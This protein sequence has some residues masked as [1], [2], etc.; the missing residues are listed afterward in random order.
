MATPD[1]EA[2]ALEKRRLEDT[3]RDQYEK[4]EG[5]DT[6]IGEK[7]SE[8]EQLKA[9]VKKKQAENSGFRNEVRGFREN[10]EQLEK[11]KRALEKE[12]DDAR[13]FGKYDQ[14]QRDTI[15]KQLDTKKKEHTET[16]KELVQF[17]NK[18]AELEATNTSLHKELDSAEDKVKEFDRTFTEN[19]DA[20]ATLEQVNAD[21]ETIFRDLGDNLTVKDY[22][23]HVREQHANKLK[24]ESSEA[25]FERHFDSQHMQ[26]GKNRHVSG[27]SLGDQLEDT[28]YESGSQTGDETEDPDRT[29]TDM[30][31]LGLGRTL[32]PHD[33]FLIAE[34]DTNER[35]AMKKKF[36]EDRE[37][38]EMKYKELEE[39]MNKQAKELDSIKKAQA[40]R[41]RAAAVPTITKRDSGT[42]KSPTAALSLSGIQEIISQP[43][44]MPSPPAAVPTVETKDAA[45]TNT[46]HA[47]LQTLPGVKEIFSPPPPAKPFKQV[48]LDLPFWL[49][50]ILF[51]MLLF[52]AI[53]YI[54]LVR[55]RH[56]WLE[57]NDITHAHL[58]RVQS[59]YAYGDSGWFAPY[60]MRFG[61]MIGVDN[62]LLG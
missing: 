57:A 22:V 29:L 6:T 27:A 16:R 34:E 9:D 20:K 32:T 48:L 17:K 37:E 39:K 43:P 41:I 35:E 42:S 49:K 56:M 26:N 54:A 55:E 47:P 25:S 13:A 36:A 21:F 28:G 1:A 14:E 60:I 2:W 58:L 10:S 50:I 4:L 52:Y 62:S 45:A 61:D 15:Q 59:T 51:L 44:I 33:F 46:V 8:I 30:D 23:D 18:V 53:S 12:R 31:K 24:R 7:E 11:A 3:I 40:A 19:T 38:M 5:R